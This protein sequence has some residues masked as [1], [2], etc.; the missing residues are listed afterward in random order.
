MSEKRD[1]YEVLGV[2]H[3]AGPEE[4]KRAYRKLALKFH[5]DQNREDPG[6]ETRFKEAAEAYDVL[7]DEE[8]RKRYDQFGHAGV[9]AASGG[10]GGGGGGDPF[11][12]AGE[13]RGDRTGRGGGHRGGEGVNN[14]VR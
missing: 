13:S 6:A 14:D 11:G 2:G 8:K 12:G 10:S 5:P 3:D 7:G 1:Y 9:H 4:I